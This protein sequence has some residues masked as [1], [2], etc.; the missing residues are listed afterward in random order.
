MATEF[1][2]PTTRLNVLLCTSNSHQYDVSWERCFA[3]EERRK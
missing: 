3:T 2:M 1:V